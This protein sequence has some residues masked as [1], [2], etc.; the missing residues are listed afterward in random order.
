[1]RVTN[2]NKHPIQVRLRSATNS[3]DYV[4]LAPRGKVTLPPGYT[5]DANWKAANPQVLVANDT[6]PAPSA[7]PAASTAAPTH[8][9][10]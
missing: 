10:N 4:H 5:V 9:S 6:Q 8:G 7:T 2:M 1:M 3:I